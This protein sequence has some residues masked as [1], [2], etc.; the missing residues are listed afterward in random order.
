[1]FKT[2]SLLKHD[3]FPLPSPPWLCPCESPPPP[4]LCPWPPCWKK[5]QNRITGLFSNKKNARFAIASLF[6]QLSAFI[7]W[8][9]VRF[10][11]QG[12]QPRAP[13]QLL[14]PTKQKQRKRSSEMRTR[15][16]TRALPF[17]QKPNL[18]H[19]TWKTNMPTR[20]TMRPRIDTTRR[21]SCFTSGGS[22]NR[23]TA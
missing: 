16:S 9:R 21:R 12:C 20:L 14:I 5:N 15:L 6:L 23:S 18:K 2:I 4:W 13:H 10:C 22:T 19:F 1:M 7:K 8:R 17:V 3:E 11:Q